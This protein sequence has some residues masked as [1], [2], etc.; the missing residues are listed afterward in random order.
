MLHDN[1]LV[2]PFDPEEVTSGGI[3]IPSTAKEKQTKGKVIAVGPGK[4]D[5]TMQV[6]EGETVLFGK[7]DGTEIKYD[8]KEYLI[9]KQ[10]RIYCIL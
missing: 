7:Y 4:K 10:D 2:L 5:E 3:Y 1:V 8:G 6:K 9:L